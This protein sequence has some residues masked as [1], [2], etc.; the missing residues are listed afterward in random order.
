MGRLVKRLQ[1]VKRLSFLPAVGSWFQHA[2]ETLDPWWIWLVLLEAE[3]RLV[4]VLLTHRYLSKCVAWF[5]QGSPAL[6]PVRS[7]RSSP[8]ASNK[9]DMHRFPAPTVFEFYHMTVRNN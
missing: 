1:D 9:E 4:Q 8:R 3:W 5:I 6:S 2:A 7:R